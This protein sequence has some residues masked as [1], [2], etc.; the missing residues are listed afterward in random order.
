MS[1][2]TPNLILSTYFC[3]KFVNPEKQIYIPK[4][5][6]NVIKNLYSKTRTQWDEAD[7]RIFHD[8]LD[9]EFITRYSKKWIKFVYVDT[10]EYPVS[11][12]DIRIMV[13]LDYIKENPQWEKVF[14]VDSLTVKCVCN[15]FNAVDN[16]LNS[17]FIATEKKKLLSNSMF[18]DKL[19]R[20]GEEVKDYD[21]SERK[22][23]NADIVG[24]HRMILI[25]FL[26]Q[27]QELLIRLHE[28]YKLRKCE[29][30]SILFYDNILTGHP[31]HTLNKNYQMNGNAQGNLMFTFN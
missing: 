20:I 18:V 31:L 14:I 15:P 29:G 1:G 4:N 13:A 2:N 7:I 27:V 6:F 10:L 9:R 8:G 16:N 30:F 3:K 11:G 12:K 5:D 19:E 23:L 22:T 26:E 17:L 28:H 25:P 21:L 24:G